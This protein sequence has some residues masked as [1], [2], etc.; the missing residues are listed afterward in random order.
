M[1][2]S[3]KRNES[4]GDR[5]GQK[6]APSE[7]SG[8]VG[9][10]LLWGGLVVAVLVLGLG[11]LVWLESGQDKAG[12]GAPPAQDSIPLQ[13]VQ[14][15][16]QA[17]KAVRPDTVLATVNKETIRL[18]D[19]ENLLKAIPESQRKAYARDKQALLESLIKQTVLLQEAERLD[20]AGGVSSPNPENATAQEKAKNERLNAFLEREVLNDIR[21]QESELHRFYEDNKEQMPEESSFEE[22]QAQLRPYVLQMKQRQAVNDYIGRLINKASITRNQDWIET[23]KA[24]TADN[25]L[26]R[27]LDTG[28]PVLAD[29]GR[30]TCI[31]C[32]M[33]QPILEEL[34]EQY[35][36]EAEILILDVDEYPQ[37]TR[38]AGIRAIPTQIFYDTTGKE[39]TRHQG[40]MDKESIIKELEK[41]KK[42]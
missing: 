39:V 31:P 42:S 4:P 29:F 9:K 40:F 33:M 8:R 32:K 18:E 34:Q 13:D 14:G 12:Q 2:A 25:P 10:K 41:L 7:P 37:L 19:L 30:G 35:K 15:E 36:G 17:A 1:T 38:N 11:G 24:A 27:A 6:P 22:V 26:S 3:D 20:W 5:P 28:R 16:T 21:V 23:Q